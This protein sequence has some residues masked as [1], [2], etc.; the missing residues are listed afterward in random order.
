MRVP[1]DANIVVHDVQ[2]VSRV[3]GSGARPK[4]VSKPV[5]PGHHQDRK[6][7]GTEHGGGGGVGGGVHSGRGVL[8]PQ[9]LGTKPNDV[10]G[11]LRGRIQMWE[12]KSQL[13]RDEKCTL[14]STAVDP[15]PKLSDRQEM[16]RS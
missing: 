12:M 7:N 6:G 15:R 16:D 3:W 8:S 9:T 5:N 13:T 4:T 10:R 11:G 14:Y 2:T 1:D